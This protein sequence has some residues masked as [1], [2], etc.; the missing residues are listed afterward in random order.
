[1]QRKRK[2]VRE[3]GNKITEKYHA[4]ETKIALV[5]EIR[6]KITEKYYARET[7]IVSRNWG[8]SYR[9]VL[10]KRNE[11]WFEKSGIKLQRST[12]QGKRKLFQEIG[13]EVTEKYYPRETK[14]GSRN[15][16]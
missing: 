2:L 4:R 11:N 15:Q 12:M 13:G 10:S 8:E 5:Q 1:M 9:K 14:I 6:N 3:I 16:E 7:K